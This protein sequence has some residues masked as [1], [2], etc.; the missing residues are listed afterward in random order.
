MT[1]SQK[2]AKKSKKVQILLKVLEVIVFV[3]FY[4]VM[5]RR[6]CMHI[7]SNSPPTLQSATQ[8]SSRYKPDPL[9]LLY[10][11]ILCQVPVKQVFTRYSPIN[12]VFTKFLYYNHQMS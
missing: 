3:Y 8:V 11:H 5:L 2:S 12:L 1:S 6:L 10:N 7:T 4:F 9:S